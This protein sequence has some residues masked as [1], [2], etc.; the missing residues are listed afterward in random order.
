[1]PRTAQSS[2]RIEG[3]DELCRWRGR[4]G[5]A[6][7]G[8]IGLRS[9]GLIMAALV[10]VAWLSE[11]EP[12]TNGAHRH[13]L[14]GEP[15]GG[16][17]SLAVCPD[18][19]KI[20]TIDCRGHLALWHTDGGWWSEKLFEL[21]GDAYPSA[22]SPDGRFLAGGGESVGLCELGPAGA[23]KV[24]RLPFAGVRAMAFS[25]DSKTLA[26]ALIR[27]GDIVLWDLTEGRQRAT[28]KTGAS[29]AMSIA[30]S[31]DGRYLATGSNG[32][33]GSFTVWNLETGERTLRI[34]GNFGPVRGLAF[35][36]DGTSIATAGVYERCVRLWDAKT[37]RLLRSLAGHKMGTT[38]VAFSPDGTIL[39]T[40]GNDGMGRLWKIAT[41]E[42]QDVL[43]GHAMSLQGV[44]F[45]PD[46]LTLAAIA[47]GDNDVRMWDMNAG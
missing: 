30:F 3:E 43:D 42:L 17:R 10:G 11:R 2:P 21:G 23:V 38:G 24:L 22:F 31:P 5:V 37:G 32:L 34:N 18:G 19:G 46:G 16:S 7:F 41:G 40:V 36:R 13:L 28:M 35:S 45:S 47:I 25:P 15:G 29:S 27:S 4:I 6:K 12:R 33:I 1:M 14:P 44:A 20:A 26:A 39:A 8:L 9:L